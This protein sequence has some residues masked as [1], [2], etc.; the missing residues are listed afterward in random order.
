MPRIFISYRRADSQTICGRMYDRLKAAFGGA[1]NVFKDVESIPPGVDFREHIRHAVEQCDAQVVIMGPGW[2]DARDEAGRRRLDDPDD[3]VR[4]EIEAALNRGIVVAP[5][6]VS[7]ASMP[8]ADDLPPTLR[9]LTFRNAAPVRDDPDFDHD[10]ER[11]IRG[12]RRAIRTR[13]VG[14]DGPLDRRGGHARRWVWLIA[15]LAALIIAVAIVLQTRGPGDGAG[16]SLTPTHTPDGTPAASA[17]PTATAALPP[18]ATDTPRPAASATPGPR[19]SPTPPADAPVTVLASFPAPG[20]MAEGL[21]WDGASLWVAD[22]SAALFK[23]DTAG[24]TLGAYEPP[25]YTP[26]GMA[27]DGEALW[28]YATGIGGI[29]H[30]TIEGRETVELGSFEAPTRITGGGISHDLEWDGA[31]LWYANQ[32]N[33]YKLDTVGEIVGEF[34]F[35]KNVTGLAWDGEYLWLAYNEFPD[36]AT[37]V[38]VD[39]TGDV[40]ASFGAPVFQINALAWGDGCLWALGK[41]SLGGDQWVYQL[42]VTRAGAIAAPRR[43]STWRARVLAERDAPALPRYAVPGG[44]PTSPYVAGEGMLFRVVELALWS[45]DPGAA[46]SAVQVVL[47]DGEDRVYTPAGLDLGSNGFVLGLSDFTAQFVMEASP[48][49]LLIEYVAQTAASGASVR[50]DG[51]LEAFT[52]SPDG[53]PVITLVWQIPDDAAGLVLT[54]PGAPVYRLADA[55]PLSDS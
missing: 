1:Q 50:Q 43:Q 33:V 32:Y 24:K 53:W 3:F 10:M 29:Y 8:P 36:N 41:D 54:V 13:S 5:V 46:L 21:T 4:L 17:P 16:A 47:R 25:G 52:P 40:L 48:P 9:A 20:R 39:T 27:W 14:I 45:D 37:V 22:N 6:L 23:V 31:H 38:V 49:R 18:V 2:L 34:A 26:K 28:L 42:D 35:P 30:F 11:L 44:T 51:S 12:L 19:P 15:G 7:G 55:G